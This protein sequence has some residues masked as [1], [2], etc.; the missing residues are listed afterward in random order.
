MA[1]S[2]SPTPISQCLG[3]LTLISPS[4]RLATRLSNDSQSAFFVLCAA[5]WGANHQGMR[6][7][8]K[9]SRPRH[10]GAVVFVV[11]GVPQGDA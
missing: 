5:L 11:G 1:E 8:F 9:G 10:G 7:C 3:H 6:R 2:P 4:T